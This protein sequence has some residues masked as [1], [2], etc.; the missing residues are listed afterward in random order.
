ME[1][2]NLKQCLQ[3]ME[4]LAPLKYA[5]KS[6]DNVGLLIEPSSHSEGLNSDL[7]DRIFITNDL[8]EK[9][10]NEIIEI[11]QSSRKSDSNDNK[12][13]LSFVVSYHPTL[14]A[15]F[16]RLAQNDTQSR[17]AIR[18]I[19]NRIAVYSPHTALDSVNNGLNDWLASGLGQGSVTVIQPESDDPNAGQGRIMTLTNKTELSVLID[20]IKKH[21]GIEHVRVAIGHPKTQVGEVK[22]IQRI[23]LCAGAGWSIVRK[24]LRKCDL[25]L[26]GEMRHHE[27]LEAVGK[28]VNVLICE[29]SHTERGF[30]TEFAKRIEK[31][32]GGT[33]SEQAKEEDRVSVHV[34]KSDADPL[35][36]L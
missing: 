20:R 1:K 17:I 34:C 5:D 33:I 29:H 31:Q 22:E 14:F 12:K 16:K 25:V 19:E 28:G 10:L 2:L 8:T 36:T 23:A 26:T 18:C 35:V 6:F 15:S 9:V 32:L 13:P 7:V 27:V 4:N 30:L 11:K 21:L 3:V 24:D